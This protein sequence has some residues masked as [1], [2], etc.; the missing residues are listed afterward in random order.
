MTISFVSKEY[1]KIDGGLGTDTLKLDVN[2]DLS[3]MANGKLSNVEIIDLGTASSTLTLTASS[4]L[5][6][7]DADHILRVTGSHGTIDLDSGWIATSSPNHDFQIY[8]KAGASLWVQAE[9]N[10]V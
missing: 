9:L 3:T 5:G 10:V 7:T 8:T 2:L 6:I 4:V 1:L